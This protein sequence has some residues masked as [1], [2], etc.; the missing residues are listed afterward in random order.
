MLRKRITIAALAGLIVLALAAPRATAGFD[1]AGHD[2]ACA[3]TPGYTAPAGSPYA[4]PAASPAAIAAQGR[5]LIDQQRAL[6]LNQEV[7]RSS[8]ET[9]RE[10]IGFEM[11]KRDALPTPVD[12]Q[13]RDRRDQVREAQLDPPVEDVLSGKALNDLLVD[14]QILQQRGVEGPYIPLKD[15][16]V[17]QINVAVGGTQDARPAGQDLANSW[18][19]LELVRDM[20]AHGLRFAP[21]GADNAAGYLALQRALAQYDTGLQAYAGA[22]FPDRSGPTGLFG[23]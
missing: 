3:N 8:I 12:N 22:T 13:E 23:R 7:Q 6:L 20:T 16:L 5:F 17:S 1:A 15:G 2:T 19:V 14:C 18:T 10:Q 9:Q 21:A 4:V 11:W